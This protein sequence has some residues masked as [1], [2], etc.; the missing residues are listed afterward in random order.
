MST[1]VIKIV[2]CDRCDRCAV[3]TEAESVT[4]MPEGWYQLTNNSG[5]TSH[6]C[7]DCVR[8]ALKV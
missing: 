6:L 3:K 5:K 4:S 2:K 1:A 8:R 7:P